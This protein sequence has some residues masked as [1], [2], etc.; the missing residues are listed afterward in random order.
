[1]SFLKG[2][3]HVTDESCN[4]VVEDCSALN[5]TP[6]I[7]EFKTSWKQDQWDNKVS[8]LEEK[9]ES[10]T[11]TQGGGVLTLSKT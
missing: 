6:L 7:V 5:I 1:M 2:G 3:M 9:N 8:S 10:V 11:K 4:F